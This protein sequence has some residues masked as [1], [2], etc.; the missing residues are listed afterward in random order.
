[1]LVSSFLKKLNV[2][3][4]F[5]IGIVF[6]IRHSGEPD[7]W[8]QIKTGKTILEQGEV[9]KVDIFSYT[10]AGTPWLN[11]KW[12][13]EVIMAW[14]D[15]MVGPELIFLLQILVC[16]ITIGLLLK[17]Y[18]TL[19]KHLNFDYNIH[20]P[21][22]CMLIL[23]AGWAFRINGRP[24]M[25]SHLF[26]VCYLFIFIKFVANPKTKL[27]FL[28][29]PFQ[30]MWTNMHEGYGIGIVLL[31]IFL[32]GNWGQFFLFKTQLNLPK[33]RLVIFSL[34]TFVAFL[35][36]SIHPFGFQLLTHPFE[37]YQ[38][39]G[40]NKFT[41]E[42][43]SFKQS[44][45]W[46]FSSYIHLIFSVLTCL[47]FIIFIRKKHNILFKL[48]LG[49]IGVILALLYLGFSAYRNIPFALFAAFPFVSLW[50]SSKMKESV[51]LF[52][53][54]AL[55][56]GLY[57]LIVTNTFYQ[58]IL[59]REKFGLRIDYE[60]NPIGVAQF[61]VDNNISGHGFVDY[62]SS[63][64]LLYA[65][66]EFK[67]YIDLRDLDIFEGKFIE[68]I[69]RTYAFPEIKTK[70]GLNAFD[71]LDK[72]DDFQYVSVI[73]NPAFMK[74]HRYMLSKANYCLVYCD[75]NSSLY[76][77]RN[78]ENSEIITEYC[79]KSLAE[80]HHILSEIKP[81]KFAQTINYVFWPFYQPKEPN[82]ENK[83]KALAELK[84]YYGLSAMAQPIFTP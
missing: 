69:Q 40:N 7:V 78:S 67:T 37:I 47:V 15:S 34:T 60:R 62:L 3:L 36:T 75:L 43:L 39:L 49:L 59:P 81:G 53:T 77:K 1:M 29:I 57:L 21:L 45:Y 73:N 31:L 79:T 20:A 71:F 5:L 13:T 51:L 27:S 41:T 19:A 18:K 17:A 35:A 28:L 6:S 61:I 46:N 52:S 25:I 54:T 66:P 11:V 65:V 38:Q 68:N 84:R 82:I 9:P 2:F 50:I 8:W 72:I 22:F 26:T 83:E 14:I 4:I 58:T 42:L 64:Y 55:G 48:N 16:L 12:F 44:A 56:C 74:F 63:S 30:I 24:E 23:L 33:K 76:V 70:S 32:A 10:Y 80:K